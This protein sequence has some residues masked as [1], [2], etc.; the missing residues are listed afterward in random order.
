MDKTQHNNFGHGATLSAIMPIHILSII[1][2]ITDTY[3]NYSSLPF[4][5]LSFTFHIPQTLQ[6]NQ[7]ITI[8]EAWLL[9]F[10]D[11]QKRLANLLK[12]ELCNQGTITNS[13]LLAPMVAIQINHQT[14]HAAL[15][16]LI[17]CP[18]APCGLGTT[19]QTV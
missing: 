9:Q 6:V 3:N 11:A 13:S 17:H 19:N 1:S 16:S 18:F 14:K 10:Q 8:M 2:Q 15:P 12:Q 4:D 5:E 7:S